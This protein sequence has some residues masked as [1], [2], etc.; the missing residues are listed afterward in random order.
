[1]PNPNRYVNKKKEQVTLII[2]GKELPVIQGRFAYG[3]DI[4]ASSYNAT[5]A[6]MPGKDSW[7]DKITARGSF[8]DSKLFIGP[9]LV[10]TGRLYG[11]ENSITPNSITKTLEFYS[12]T[13]DLV[14]SDIPPTEGEIRHSDLKLI[15]E[16]LCGAKG[17]PVTFLDDPGPPFDVVEAKRDE[18]ETVAKYL[19]RLAS[20]RG[21]FV[22]CD[23]KSGVVF[24][25]AANA[26]RP[27]AHIEYP[28]R[29]VVEH[30]AKFDDRL[31]FHKYFASSV[32]GDGKA[33]N[34][35][36]TDPAVP[37]SRQ[38]L[39]EANDVDESAIKSVVEWKMLRIELEALSVSF[40]VTD[41]FDD[42]GKLWR[43][44]KMVTAKS[45][46]LEIPEEKS[47]VIR[48]VEFSWSPN[49]RRAV[50]NLV[51]PLTTESGILKAGAK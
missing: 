21:L 7:L 48:Q 17:F 44:N 35:T 10:C 11:R 45:A 46:A 51:P 6:W 28:G 12:K 32:T 15:A 16:L 14:D 4:L 38:I 40:P 3:I 19:Q 18:V 2:G 39:F 1:M 8:A 47:F 41:W 37:A 27:V 13:A 49:Q 34:A 20:Q 42:D 26:G 29:V 5:I 25:K 33:L 24:Q 23:E 9:E 30:K 22:S 36:A 50:L 43:P 31:R